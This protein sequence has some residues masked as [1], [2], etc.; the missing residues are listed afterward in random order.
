MDMAT[1][2]LCVIVSVLFVGYST[3]IG[4]IW[5]GVKDMQGHAAVGWFVFL[6][7][8]PSVSLVNATLKSVGADYGM[9]FALGITALLAAPFFALGYKVLYPW[10]RKRRGYGS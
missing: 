5:R 8:I 9:A 10:M 7:G 1:K 2:L 6:I 4:L 3:F